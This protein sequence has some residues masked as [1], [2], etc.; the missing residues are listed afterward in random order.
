[1]HLPSRFGIV[2]KIENKRI[3]ITVLQRFIY[4]IVRGRNLFL[5]LEQHNHESRYTLDEIFFIK[6]LKH[7]AIKDRY[8]KAS[9]VVD[10]LLGNRNIFSDKF[11][12]VSTAGCLTYTKLKGIVYRIR[13]KL[14]P[15]KEYKLHF[16]IDYKYIPEGFFQRDIVFGE[17]RFLFFSTYEQL[18]HLFNASTWYMDGT[19]RIVKKN[20]FYAI[21]SSP[22]HCLYTLKL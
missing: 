20:G 16:S 21:I 1:M 6:E 18:G 7:E 15:P 17:D 10:R 2:H 3:S 13:R 9:E 22:C 8:S 11:R 5:R 14:C 4:L 19:I 12:I